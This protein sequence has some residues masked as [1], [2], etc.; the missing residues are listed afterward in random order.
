VIV[1]PS[2]MLLFC[3]GKTSQ[4]EKGISFDEM[5]SAILKVY[6]YGKDGTNWMALKKVYR[7]GKDGTNWMALKII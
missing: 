4:N 1:A 5:K 2:L 6:R 3:N 7:Y